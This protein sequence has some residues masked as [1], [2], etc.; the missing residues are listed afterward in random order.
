MALAVR[1]YSDSDW[2]SQKDD[3]KSTSGVSVMLCG[4]PVIFKSR[5]QRTVALSTAEAEYMAL[6][7]CVQEVVWLRSLLNEIRFEVVAPTSIHVDNQSAIA[8]AK[9]V[10]Y[11]S[12]AK[13]IDIRL[14]FIRDHVAANT[15]VVKYVPSHLQLADYLTKPQPRARFRAL[16]MHSGVGVSVCQLRGLL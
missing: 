13:H 11:Q 1:A 8:I 16:L 4:G 6:A 14:H 12:R 3:R 2:A 7:M 15:I 9:N 10:G 5:L